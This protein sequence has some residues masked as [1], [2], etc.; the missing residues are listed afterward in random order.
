MHSSKSGLLTALSA[1][2]ELTQGVLQQM[3]FIGLPGANK[4]RE[5]PGTYS[6]SEKTKTFS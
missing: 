2:L 1:L 5:N 4:F 6:L 3:T